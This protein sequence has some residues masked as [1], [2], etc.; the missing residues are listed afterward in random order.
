MC[1]LLL[2]M[3]MTSFKPWRKL[4]M[5]V[6]PEWMDG[7]M[8]ERTIVTGSVLRRTLPCGAAAAAV[9]G[10]VAAAGAGGG[11]GGTYAGCGMRR[12]ASEGKA[13]LTA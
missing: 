13:A 11:G 6:R 1:L 2:L 7:W 12:G 10:A 9:A 4:G 3:M 5:D 8:D